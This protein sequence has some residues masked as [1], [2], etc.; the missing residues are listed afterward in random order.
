[1]SVMLPGKVKK[2]SLTVKVIQRWKGLAAEEVSSLDW[3]YSNIAK[4]Q[5]QKN[6]EL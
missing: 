5:K 1:M 2:P 6:Q 4:K 3:K